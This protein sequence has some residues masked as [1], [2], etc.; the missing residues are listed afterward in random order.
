MPVTIITYAQTN[1]PAYNN[2]NLVASSVNSSQTDFKY[3]VTVA[4]ND[5]YY[6]DNVTL[7]IPARPDN[8]K[9]YYNPQR[10]VEAQIKSSFDT[11]ITDFTPALLATPSQIK[12][13]TVGVDEEYGNPVSGFAG[14]SASYYVWNAAYDA[15]DFTSFVYSSGSLAKDLTLVPNLTETINYN[16]KY[17]MKSWHRGFASTN[18]RYCN[19]KCYNSNGSI[20]LQSSILENNYYNTSAGPTGYFRN[21]LTLN[22]S[23]NG[24]NTYSGTI[25]SKSSLFD[26]IVPSNTAYYT[27][28]FSDTNFGT[29]NTNTYRINIAN[30]CSKYSRYTVHFL[31]KLGNYDSF[32]FILLSKNTTDKETD[33]YKKIPYTLDSSNKYRYEKYTNDTVIYN[34]VLTNKITLNSDWVNEATYTWLRDLFMSPDI[35]LENSSGDIISVKCNI[36]NY[37]SKKKVNDKLFNATIDLENSLQDVRQRA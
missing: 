22:C 2:Q 35:K 36:K 11:T 32:T 28:Q 27:I 31:N 7:K 37:E 16:Q 30:Y 14:T 9:L 26:D 12:K 1:T 8:K 24:L 18:L 23:P 17:L 29:P 13:V 21:Y 10:I 19:I 3:V 5:G 4:I 6:S 20:L 25:T 34:T 33:M 15:L